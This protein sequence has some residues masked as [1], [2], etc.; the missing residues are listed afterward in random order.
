MIP[1]DPRLARAIV[2]VNMCEQ[3]YRWCAAHFGVRPAGNNDEDGGRARLGPR[4]TPDGRGANHR[5]DDRRH[6]DAAPMALDV[7][8]EFRAPPDDRL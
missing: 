2:E 8:V 3:I 1:M 6:L 5:P 7:A 4:R